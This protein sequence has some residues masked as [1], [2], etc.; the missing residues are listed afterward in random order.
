MANRNSVTVTMPNYQTDGTTRGLFGIRRYPKV[1]PGG[2]ITVSIDREKREKLATPKEKVNW[3]NTV[4]QSISML[5]SAVS[6]V[7]LI[8]RIK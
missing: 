3:A 5:T 6:L 7:I 2:V 8:D 4:S 1:Q